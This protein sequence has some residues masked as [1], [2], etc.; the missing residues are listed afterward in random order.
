MHVRLTAVPVLALLGL[1]TA[2]PALAQAEL[3]RGASNGVAV[4]GFAQRYPFVDGGEQGEA[5][6]LGGE[7]VAH[8]T[9]RV[10]VG[11]GV[12]GT[13][14]IGAGRSVTVPTIA[15]TY[16]VS[17][18]GRDGKAEPLTLALSLGAGLVTGERIA[19]GPTMA[20]SVGAA[21]AV[22]SGSAAQLVPSITAAATFA[23]LN[24]YDDSTPYASIMQGGFAAGQSITLGLALAVGPPDRAM[25]FVRPTVTLPF[26]EGETEPLLGMSLGFGVAY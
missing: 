13:S 25:L 15:L 17:R 23:F 3:F 2:S 1:W 19:K 18:Q 4:S 24:E 20:V 5:W 16:F 6:L 14:N 21:R 11:F 26:G 8:L 9:P 12:A 10:G 7:A 22:V